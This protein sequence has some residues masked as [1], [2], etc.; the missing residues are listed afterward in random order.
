MGRVVAKQRQDECAQLS[1]EIRQPVGLAPPGEFVQREYLH[2][3]IFAVAVIISQL[4]E[5]PF[6]APRIIR[7]V[8]FG[9]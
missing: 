6:G 2:A 9:G 5:H 4:S 1:E 8:M 3:A 7:R